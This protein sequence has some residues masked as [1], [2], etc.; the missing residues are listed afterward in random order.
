MDRLSPA[1]V[2]ADNASLNK[3]RIVLKLCHENFF[4][5][6]QKL[7]HRPIHHHKFAVFK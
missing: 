1:T 4:S 6:N 3:K 7:L 5:G 2:I